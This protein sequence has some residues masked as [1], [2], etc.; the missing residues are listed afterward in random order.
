MAVNSKVVKT[1]AKTALEGNMLRAI[2]SSCI[3]IFSFF[4]CYYVSFLV[5]IISGNII[6][7]I[8]NLSLILFLI[9]PLFLGTLRFFWRLLFSVNDNPVTVFYYF[10]DKKLYL[11]TIK[12][13]FAIFI[14]ALPIAA[15]LF[16]PTFA[17]WIISQGTVFELIDMSIPS[18]T[19]SLFNIYIFLRSL[20]IVILTL[21][22]IKF[23]ISPILF[24][25]D[26][27]MDVGE[28]VH[29]SSIISRKSSID[30]IY[31]LFS[32]LGII[33]ISVFVIPL[34]ITLPYL[35]TS[36][37]VH[38]RFVIAEYNNHIEKSLNNA[39]PTF[40]AGAIDE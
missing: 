17:V 15:L 28:A 20:S 14:K 3:L 32:F 29:I 8:F 10:T 37:C 21:F 39:F 23:Y 13:L 19:A 25:A 40:E 22:L 16:L 38:I 18:W 1:T 33:V 11:K 31:L 4:I 27:N 6:A 26:E 34:V 5:Q 7:K 9:I 2:F 12:L 30:F 35:L 36:L 24:V